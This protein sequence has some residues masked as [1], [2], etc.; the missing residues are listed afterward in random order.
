MHFF[1]HVQS[2]FQ[3]F[4]FMFKFFILQVN[5][6]FTRNLNSKP[7]KLAKPSE[8]WNWMF[9]FIKLIGQRFFHTLY[10]KE[11]HIDMKVDRCS[12]KIQSFCKEKGRMIYTH[13]FQFYSDFYLQNTLR[14]TWRPQNLLF[15]LHCL[16]QAQT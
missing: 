14:S 3:F 9:G 12:C 15:L 2:V 7:I 10:W 11:H 13:F 5:T 1:L 8:L 6:A 4:L 16:F